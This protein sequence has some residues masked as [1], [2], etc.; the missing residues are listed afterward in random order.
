VIYF[1]PV[2]FKLSETADHSLNKNAGQVSLPAF[3]ELPIA[4]HLL[5][6]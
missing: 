3:V 4:A 6:P 1:K 2:Y 5:R